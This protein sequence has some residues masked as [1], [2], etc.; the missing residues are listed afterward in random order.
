VSI[1]TFYQIFLTLK[2]FKIPITITLLPLL[3]SLDEESYV[4]ICDSALSRDLFPDDY[5]CLG[6]NENRPLKWLSLESLQKRVYATQGDVWA[7]GV[8]YWELVTL[9]QM[10]HEEVDIFELTNYLA[11]GFRLEQPVNCPDEL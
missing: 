8:T 3:H 1:Y 5:D 6:D 9:A 10:P 11:A 4:K 2:A 7:L